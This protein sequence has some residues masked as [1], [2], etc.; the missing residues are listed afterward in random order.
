MRAERLLIIGLLL[1]A[2]PAFAQKITIDYDRDFDF[3]KVQTFAYVETS[4]SNAEDQL[5]DGRIKDAVIKEMTEGGLQHVDSDADLLITYHLTSK[6]NTSFSTTGYGYGGYGYYPDYRYR[7]RSPTVVV[8]GDNRLR[9]TSRGRVQPSNGVNR[10]RRVYAGTLGS[11][12]RRT[13]AANRVSPTARRLAANNVTGRNPQRS[14]ATTSTGRR[15]VDS[16]RTAPAQRATTATARRTT[17]DAAR[18][19]VNATAQ[20]P[21]RRT[22]SS[23]TATRQASPT[24]AT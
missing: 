16:P 18:R 22:T 13:S 4:D 21:Q 11:S 24:R 14:A 9:T 3:D 7:Y 6:E 2:S 15:A 10:G 23:A 5:M 1:V 19:S 8:Y 12:V 17:A 20:Q